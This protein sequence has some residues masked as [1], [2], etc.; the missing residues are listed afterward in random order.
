MLVVGATVSGATVS[1][2]TVSGAMVVGVAAACATGIVLSPDAK[3]DDASEPHALAIT[4][5]INKIAAMVVDLLRLERTVFGCA[6]FRVPSGAG[7]SIPPRSVSSSLNQIVDSALMTKTHEL[8]QLAGGVY[9]WL[10]NEPNHSHSNAGVVIAADAITVIDAGLVPRLSQPLADELDQISGAPIKRLV[11]TGSHIDVVG[12]SSAFPL[13]AVY[14][15]AQTSDHLDQEPNPEIWQRLHP[16]FNEDFVELRTRAVTHT[17]AEPAHLCPAS[18]AVPLGGPQFESL[19]VQVPGANVVFTGM[20]ASFGVT[21]LGFEADF[22]VWISSLDQLTGYGE[23][24][25]PAHGPIGGVE[26]IAELRAYLQACVDAKGDPTALE[27]GPWDQWTHQHF[28][29]INIERAHMLQAGDASPPP[30]MIKL[31]GL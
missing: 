23:I 13:A 10:A 27:S 3:L 12:G 5:T 1:G 22:D 11:V 17:V 20:L 29:P 2:A 7:D 31:L 15:S 6:V 24:F 4:A 9:A 21:P 26:E 25:V 28:T 30:S 8:V 14:G 18:I 16:G 19:A